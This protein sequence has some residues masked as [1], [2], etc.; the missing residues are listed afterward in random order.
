MD[1]F[2]EIGRAFTA[3]TGVKVVFSYGT[4]AQLAKQI[5]NG[6]PFDLFAAADSEHVDSLV[7]AK[8]LTADSRAIYPLGSLRSGCPKESRAAFV[9]SRI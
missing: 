2:G 9:S 4:T 6:A 5:E 3:K 8:K 1:I 7:T